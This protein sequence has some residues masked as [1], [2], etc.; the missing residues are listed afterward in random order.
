MDV[1]SSMGGSSVAILQEDE[2]HNIVAESSSSSATP[3]Q[4]MS[5]TTTTTTC[6]SSLLYPGLQDYDALLRQ[7]LR[8][9]FQDHE[10]VPLQ[11]KAL[12][13]AGWTHGPRG[14]VSPAGTRVYSA[15][16]ELRQDLDRW[17][18]SKITSNLLNIVEEEE[19][20]RSDDHN[21]H[22]DDDGKECLRV[23]RNT[24]IYH[25]QKIMQESNQH[26]RNP[27]NLSEN[28]DHDSRKASR[29]SRD[30][31]NNNNDA[32]LQGQEEST[33]PRRSSR[34]G[35]AGSTNSAFNNGP[36]QS[37]TATEKGT[38]LYLHRH[39]K[40]GRQATKS[41]SLHVEENIDFS[42]PT[43]EECQERMAQMDT[44]ACDQIESYYRTRYFATWRH[45]LSTN[46]SLLFYGNGS[47]HRLLSDFC[48]YELRNE[49]YAVQIDGFHPDVTIDGILNLLVHLFLD[50]VEPVAAAPVG[51][52]STTTTESGVW[53]D[54]PEVPDDENDH[55]DH[56]HHCR[57]AVAVAR[58]LARHCATTLRQPIF[59]VVHS[60]DGFLR[61]DRAQESL[62]TLVQ[63]S[64]AP[65]SCGVSAIRLVASIDHVDAGAALWS[66][67]GGGDV[68]HQFRW[69]WKA[70][71][72]YR[73]YTAELA[74]LRIDNDDEWLCGG[75]SGDSQKKQKKKLVRA[76]QQEA[77]AVHVLQNL[78]PKYTEVLQILVRLQLDKIKE[79]KKVPKQNDDAEPDMWVEFA[80]LLREC[81]NQFAVDKE[82]KLRELLSELKDHRL[83]LQATARR[84]EYVRVPHSVEKLKSILAFERGNH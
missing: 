14:Y 23:L 83:V 25:M 17:A 19:E 11:W 77:N 58:A 31:N 42:F 53:S 44:T 64:V 30:A 49:G 36:S 66:G 38:D 84:I 8:Y 50:G 56:P 13:A 24:I 62:A 12:R 72:T 68:R 7:Q 82:S 18:V 54:I 76:T 34:H 3:H 20:E 69:I 32:A 9:R 4:A 35:A 2:D 22:D 63:H 26:Q 70:V 15:A 45:L 33:R 79:H 48:E 41:A 6:P 29:S 52:P 28:D 27:E 21:D 61:T 78:A 75:K 55:G 51:R 40:K 74:L 71:H 1:E 59:L 37:V 80:I 67:G 60:L 47:K 10:F 73:P 81:K 5:P 46:H 65:D 57:R 16:L 39:S 43:L